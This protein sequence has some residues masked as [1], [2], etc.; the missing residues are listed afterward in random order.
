MVEYKENIKDD[1][2]YDNNS[3]GKEFDIIFKKVNDGANL[4]I[5]SNDKGLLVDTNISNG[6]TFNCKLS[7]LKDSNE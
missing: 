6:D 4:K 5:I 3:E 1:V 2:L 7:S